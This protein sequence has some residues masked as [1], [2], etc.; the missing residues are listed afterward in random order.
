[1]CALAERS[2]VQTG[3]PAPL[4][5]PANTAVQVRRYV[6][7]A[8]AGRSLARVRM[9]ALSVSVVRLA[10]TAL[11]RALIALLAR[12]AGLA[13]RCVLFVKEASTAGRRLI[14]ASPAMPASSV[15]KDR[16]LVL[17][18][19]LSGLMLESVRRPARAVNPEGMQERVKRSAPFV[20]QERS[21]ASELR[22]AQI[23]T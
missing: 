21:A 3:R 12:G 1:M 17:H 10:S 23:V 20:T 16:H 19:A 6:P 8:S 5:R 22:H 14:S 13:Q 9:G 7:S 11:Q 15:G 18:P 2:Q 4:V